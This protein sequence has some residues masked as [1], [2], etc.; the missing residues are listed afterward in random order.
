MVSLLFNSKQSIYRKEPLMVA[1]QAPLWTPHTH[2]RI[3]RV[4]P[5]EFG[6]LS[7]R[8]ALSKLGTYVEK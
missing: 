8:C 1:A 3:N 6:S 4:S 7:L 2:T 5:R